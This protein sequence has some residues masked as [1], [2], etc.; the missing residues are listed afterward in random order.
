VTSCEIQVRQLRL[1]NGITPF[2]K[3]IDTVAGENPAQTNYL[4]TTYNA[5]EHDMQFNQ[6]DQVM[7]LGGGCYRIGS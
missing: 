1:K 4:Y 3:Q 7:I 6:K 2:V 5:N